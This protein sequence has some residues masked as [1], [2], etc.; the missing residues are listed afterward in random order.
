LHFRSSQFG[1]HC[2]V[3]EVWLSRKDPQGAAIASRALAD[4]DIEVGDID[5]I[6]FASAPEVFEGVY[7]PDRWCVDAAAALLSIPLF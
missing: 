5:A 2:K 3:G 6:V 7:E 1:F 4:A